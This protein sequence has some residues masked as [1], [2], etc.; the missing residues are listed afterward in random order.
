ME[1]SVYRVAQEALQN[2][3]VHAQASSASVTLSYTPEAFQLSVCDDGVGFEPEKA[4]G[5]REGGLGVLGMH[6]RA[7]HLGGAL[8][9]SSKPG[10]GTRVV[11]DLPRA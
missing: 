6:E 5:Q 9:I 7:Q 11:L 2:A 10:Q 8:T 4:L 3:G 1:I